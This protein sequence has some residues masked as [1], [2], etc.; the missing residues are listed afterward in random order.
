MNRGMSGRDWA[1]LLFLS[2]IWGGS[3][4]LI[5]IALRSAQPMTV[6][7]IRVGFA[8]AGLWLFVWVRR[9]YV[10]LP[11]ET[12][13]AF[14]L[15]ALLNNVLPFILFA[16][17]QTQ[18]A[19]GLASIL[20]ATTPIWCVIV[21]HLFTDDERMTP[22]KIVGLLLGFAGV[23]VMIGAEFLRE[24]G[25]EV[26]AQL[27]CLAATLCHASA[28]VF[29][30]RFQPMGVPPVMVA[31]GQVTAASLILLPIVLIFEPP[32]VTAP[33]SFETWSA[34]IVLA[35]IC[36]AL[37][38]MLYFRL[39]AS[40]GATNSL[41]V[42]FLVPITA[43]LLGVVVLGETLAPRHFAGMALIAGGLAAIDGRLLRLARR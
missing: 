30:R 23:A 20:N 37:A 7:L 35:I 6:V 1:L 21:A 38:Y 10:K 11:R 14:L 8:A 40:A 17:G 22:A 2:I 32:W 18:I 19:S 33:L 42:T 36:T 27:A 39:L 3:F 12:I 43:I 28:T 24:I 34:L 29:A 5:E 41:L 31:T 4:F 26:A 15:L 16:Y 9:Q 13:V 25:T